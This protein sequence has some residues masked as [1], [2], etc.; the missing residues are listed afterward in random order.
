L[1]VNYIPY[2]LPQQSSL[3]TQACNNLVLRANATASKN[4]F[5]QVVSF[6]DSD[7]PKPSGYPYVVP[8]E[9]PTVVSCDKPRL[10]VHELEQQLVSYL[11]IKDI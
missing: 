2:N 1:W 7:V 8:S 3:V 10:T 9:L 11:S 5:A 6:K 4:G